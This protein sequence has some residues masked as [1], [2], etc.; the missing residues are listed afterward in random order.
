MIG[1]GFNFT[2]NTGTNAA[3]Q[4]LKISFQG[5]LEH[6]LD[7]STTA[8]AICWKDDVNTGF[9]RT[10]EDQASAICESQQLGSL[11]STDSV[12]VPIQVQTDK[13]TSKAG[14]PYD[15]HMFDGYIG[16]RYTL[17]TQTPKLEHPAG[18]RHW[19]NYKNGSS[20][21]HTLLA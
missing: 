14:A 3:L 11:Y 7:G 6:G 12:T 16:T 4:A 19:S 1:A 20:R 8:P 17:I 10:D 18:M 2:L 15:A 13:I 5:L 21:H 9:S